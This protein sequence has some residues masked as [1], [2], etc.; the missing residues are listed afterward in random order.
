MDFTERLPLFKPKKIGEREKGKGDEELR[1]R[2][3][4]GSGRGAKEPQWEL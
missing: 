1:G 3:D 2:G 4:R